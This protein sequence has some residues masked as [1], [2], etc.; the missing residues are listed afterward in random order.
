MSYRNDSN[1]LV[2]KYIENVWVLSS[3]ALSSCVI[4]KKV[5]KIIDRKF[6]IRFWVL[7][8][9]FVPLEAYIF[10]EGYLRLSSENYK[11]NDGSCDQDMKTH[12]TNFSVNYKQGK[13]MSKS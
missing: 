11:F 6:D 5:A 10:G 7:V 12:L 4:S 8:K 1:K 3:Q 13:D 2:Q 9:S